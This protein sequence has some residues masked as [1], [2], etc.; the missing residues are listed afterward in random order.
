MKRNRM[1]I[2]CV[3]GLHTWDYELADGFC[4]AYCKFCGIGK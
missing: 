3:F 4:D 1:K 2:K